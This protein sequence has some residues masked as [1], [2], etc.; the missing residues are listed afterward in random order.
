MDIIGYLF[1]SIYYR[2]SFTGALIRLFGHCDIF[3][4]S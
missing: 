2:L 3:V 1:D 4:E